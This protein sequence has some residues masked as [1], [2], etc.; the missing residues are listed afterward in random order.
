MRRALSIVF[1][2]SLFCI[3]FSCKVKEDIDYMKNIEQTAIQTSIQTSNFTIQPGDQLVITVSAKDNDVVKPFNQNY[4]SG[5]VSQFSLSS[6]NLP[7][8]AQ[9]SVSGPTYLVDSKGDILF[10]IIGKLN[11]NGKT[12]EQL[13]DEVKERLKQY[14]K[15]PGVIIRNTNF[16]VTVLGEVSRPGTYVIPDG[17]SMTVLGV[18]GMAGDLTIYGQRKN[19]LV[20][21]NVDGNTTKRYIDLTNAELINSPFY[22]IKQ[23]DVI[24]VSP[25]NTKKNSSAFGPQAGIFISIASVVVG[26][27]ALLFR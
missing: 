14:V 19:V 10:P 16:K 22:Y 13:R 23:N 4:S 25:N 18:L 7:M 20:I 9:S 15:D 26:L 3:I 11:T 8:Q 5:E 1:M 21:R 2:A 12:I 27:L 6:S 24:Y 17:Q